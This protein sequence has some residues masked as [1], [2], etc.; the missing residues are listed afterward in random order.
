MQRIQPKIYAQIL[1]QIGQESKDPK[2]DIVKFVKLLARHNNLGLAKE[3]I[4]SYSTIYNQKKN[5]VDIKIYAARE[6]SQEQESQIIK[7]VQG[8][9][10]AKEFT[11]QTEIRP[12][13]LG[14]CLITADDLQINF[15]LKNSL[16]LLKNKMI[17]K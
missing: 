4:K 14:G 16:D 1:Y 17:N 11:K 5:S 13:L 12:D 6:L 10:K 3:I 8:I 9:K 7:F 2:A 15:S